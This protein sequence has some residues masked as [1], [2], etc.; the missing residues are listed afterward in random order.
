MG[1][2]NHPEVLLG[3]PT[4]VSSAP[5]GA[6]HH[7]AI[8]ALAFKWIRV[9]FRC[10][11][12]RKSYNE[13]IYLNA[14]KRRGSPLLSF[15]A[16]RLASWLTVHFRV[17]VGQPDRAPGRCSSKV[18][19]LLPWPTLPPVRSI[20]PDHRGLSTRLRSQST[21]GRCFEVCHLLIFR[22]AERCVRDFKPAMHRRGTG[23]HCPT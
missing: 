11:Q 16:K 20:A 21:K 9:L 13:S 7:V 6:S 1:R 3:R 10:W 2:S 15:I 12:D 22:L 18:R 4:I 14:L 23:V 19:T 8:R 17:C 5:K